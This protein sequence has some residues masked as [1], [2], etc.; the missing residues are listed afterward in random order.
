VRR[1]LDIKCNAWPLPEDFYKA[2]KSLEPFSEDG[3]VRFDN[4]VMRTHSS[5][6]EGASYELYG[7]PK[8]PVF[9]IKQ[10]KSLEPFI[11]TI[12]FTAHGPNGQ[13]VSIWYGDGARGA[14][15][16]MIRK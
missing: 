8:G 16:G 10:L 14:I 3:F 11:K 4:G 7:L 6:D 12:D 13:E 5:D 2:V 1:L 15:A 9:S